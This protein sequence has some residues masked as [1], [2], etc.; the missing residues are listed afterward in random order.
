MEYR[1][2]EYTVRARPGRDQWQWTISPKD[3]RAVTGELTG[4]RDKAAK[5]ARR[6]IVRWLERSTRVGNVAG[7]RAEHMIEADPHQLP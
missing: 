4:P 2:I 6:A 1:G 5:A 3:G 7:S